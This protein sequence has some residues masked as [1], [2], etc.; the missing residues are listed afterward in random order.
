GRNVVHQ[1]SST[2]EPVRAM[3]RDSRRAVDLPPDV[4]R[5]AADLGDL[6]ALMGAMR[7]VDRIFLMNTTHSI[8]N[9]TRAVEAALRSGVRHIVSL[10]SIGA[11]LDPSPLMGR[12]H[13][14]RE[15]L[16]RSSGVG[17]SFLRPGYFMSNTLSWAA[18][19]SGDGVVRQAGGSSL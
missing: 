12:W 7:G 16:V 6:D 19:V 10:S 14:D 9:T 15:E 11:S 3:V 8:D 2:G 18:A 5:Y 13:R 17:A 1:L 4:E